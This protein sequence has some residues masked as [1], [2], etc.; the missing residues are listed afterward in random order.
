MVARIRLN[1]MRPRVPYLAGLT[2]FYET[3]A[4]QP[5][6]SQP[7]FRLPKRGPGASRLSQSEDVL[8]GARGNAFVSDKNHGI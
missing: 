8:V 7:C 3:K 6:C 4:T 5:C 2:E 1:A